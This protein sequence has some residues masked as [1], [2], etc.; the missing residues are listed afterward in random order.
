MAAVWIYVHTHRAAA[1]STFAWLNR[2]DLFW[3]TIS[4]IVAGALVSRR[5]AL[6]QI[7]ACRS[8]IAALPVERSTAQWQTIVVESV[9]A[10]VLGCGLAAVFGSLSL[11]ALVDGSI[12]T[13]M[14]TWAATTGGRG[15]GHGIRLFVPSAKGLPTVDGELMSLA[16]ELKFLPYLEAFVDTLSLGTKQKLAVLLCLIGDPKLIILDEAFNGLDPASSLVLKRHLRRRLKDRG[17]ALVLATHALDI[18]EHYADHAGLLLDGV[19]TREWTKSDI[20][21]LRSAG[22]CK[23]LICKS[24]EHPAAG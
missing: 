2:H 11:F 9:P 19:L 16:E 7:A 15:P 22:L 5:R 1:V 14:L 13:P 10:L 17:A 6:L 24:L 8:W 23:W 18:V 3:A 21:E 4:A 12:T 20:E